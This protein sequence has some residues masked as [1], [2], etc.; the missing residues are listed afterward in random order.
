MLQDSLVACRVTFLMQRPYARRASLCYETQETLA[1]WCTL[2][3]CWDGWPQKGATLQQHAC[4]EK[5]HWRYQARLKTNGASLFRSTAW[6]PRLFTRVS[7]TGPAHCCRKAWHYSR[8]AKMSISLSSCF[9]AW[10]MYL[11]P[12]AM[13]HKHRH[14]SR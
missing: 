4:W 3:G 10:R 9:G 6:G 14:S 13:M 8:S 12:R 11:F 7:T 1:S 5:K 2:F